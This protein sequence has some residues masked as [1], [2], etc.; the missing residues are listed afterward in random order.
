MVRKL[1]TEAE[2]SVKN[3]PNKWRKGFNWV[4]P[5]LSVCVGTSHAELENITIVAYFD[6]NLLLFRFRNNTFRKAAFIGYLSSH[7]TARNAL[8]FCFRNSER[9]DTRT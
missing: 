8:L 6:N 3:S 9:I 1:A 4:L 7:P 5:C 2:A